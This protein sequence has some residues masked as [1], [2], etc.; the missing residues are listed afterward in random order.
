MVLTMLFM[1][2]GIL[3]VAERLVH[4]C[5]RKPERQEPGRR[6]ATGGEAA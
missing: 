1:P 5:Q 4:R 2:Y 3:G 6:A